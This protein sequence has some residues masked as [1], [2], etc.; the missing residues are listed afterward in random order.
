M[1]TFLGDM[2][3]LVEVIMFTGVALT[4]P[5]VTRLFAGAL[6]A[7]LYRIQKYMSDS[8]PYYRT[9]KTDG[10]LTT[11]SDSVCSDESLPLATERD[12]ADLGYKALLPGET[13]IQSQR[14]NWQ[15]LVV[16]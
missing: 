6:V 8:T 12:P 11:E 10:N 16:N 9:S 2:G 14:R 7:K 13:L 4:S 3:G 5:F 15:S 1:L